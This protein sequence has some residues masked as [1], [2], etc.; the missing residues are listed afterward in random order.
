MHLPHTDIHTYTH[1]PVYTH[2]HTHTHTH[3]QYCERS[4]NILK[5]DC[6]GSPHDGLA[7]TMLCITRHS[8]A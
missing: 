6:T 3:A 2:T 5:H 7:C 8:A 1:I 4:H